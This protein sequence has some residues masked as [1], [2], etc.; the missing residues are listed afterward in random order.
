MQNDTRTATI[1]PPTA[2]TN[3]TDRS[4]VTISPSAMSRMN[5]M[6]MAKNE[7]GAICNNRLVKL[8]A[9]RNW[10]SSAP[11]MR[12]ITRSPTMIAKPVTRP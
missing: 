12:T 6:P 9:V 5:T 4:M 3:A 1:A 2:P 7:M 11:K 8:R 10:S